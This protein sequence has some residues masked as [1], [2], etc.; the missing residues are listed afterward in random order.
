MTTSS[1]LRKG[2]PGYQS[3][4]TPLHIVELVESI[5]GHCIALDPCDNA[6]SLTFATRSI[7]EP[8]DGLKFDWHKVNGLT[9]V[10]PPYKRVAPWAGKCAGEAYFGAEIILLVNACTDTK[11]FQEVVWPTC[12][13]LCFWRGRIRFDGAPAGNTLPSIFAYWGPNADRFNDVFRPYGRCL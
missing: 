8:E 2:E 1:S 6:N 9:F 11:W 10:N 5:H 3:W 4:C 7:K 13:A 12:D